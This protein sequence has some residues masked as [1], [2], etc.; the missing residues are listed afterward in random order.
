VQVLESRLNWVESSNG[1]RIYITGILTNQSKIAWRNIELECRF[2]DAK[3][4]LVDAAHP[5]IALTLQPNDD[6][7]FRAVVTSIRNSND[8]SGFRV[9]VSTAR[10]TKGFF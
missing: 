10:N 5:H 2:F 7:A 8:Y 9:S 3:G 4:N 6:A 1:S